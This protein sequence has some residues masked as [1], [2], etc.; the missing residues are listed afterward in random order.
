MNMRN[1]SLVILGIFG[2]FIFSCKSNDEGNTNNTS[3]QTT[4]QVTPGSSSNAGQGST[5]NSTQ[6]TTPDPEVMKYIVGKWKYD[7]SLVDIDGEI[8]KMVSADNWVMNYKSDGTFEESQTM[9]EGGE[10]YTSADT[11]KVEGKTLKRTGLVAFDILEINEKEMTI[12]SIGTK[13]IFKKI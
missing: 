11:Y 10:T 8:L 4:E 1:Y 13:M 2:L 9:V 7:H 12:L 5:D 3:N 6:T